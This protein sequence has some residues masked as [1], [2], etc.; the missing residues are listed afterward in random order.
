MGTCQTNDEATGFACGDPGDTACT[1]P[2]T[3]NG[4][5]TCL[6]NDEASGFACGSP[7][8]T[9]CSNPDT[10]NGMGSCAV[11][12]EA[13]G[14]AC[15]DPANTACSN[16]DI[17]DGAGNCSPNNEAAGFACGDPADT[18][19]TNPDTCNGSGT[20]QSN[21]EAAG[22]PCRPA[23]GDCDAAEA[24]DGSG[25][26][27]VDGFLS[28]STECRGPAGDCD[29]AESC[30]GFSATCP[31]DDV[32]TAGTEC[33]GAANTCDVAETCDGSSTAC[34]TDLLAPDGTSCEDGDA[35]TTSDTCT[36]GVCAGSGNSC[37]VDTFMCYK[38]KTT[39][40]LP[41]SGV[42]VDDAIDGAT[43]LDVKVHK[44]LCVPSELDAEA[45][46]DA[47]TN[48]T[49]YKVKATGH[50]KQT[51][52]AI[53]NVVGDLSL[54][55][56]RPDLLFV[57]ANVDPMTPPP[58][59][60]GSTHDVNHYKCYKARV[61]PGTPPVPPGATVIVGNAFDAQQLFAVKKVRHLC[62]PVDANGEGIENPNAYLVCYKIAAALG[63]AHY[64]EHDGLQ[65]HDQFGPHVLQSLKQT[66]LCIPSVLAP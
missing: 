29:V 44:H 58:A 50:V 26:C 17:C 18:A 54:D 11:N 47:A 19:C 39:G 66:E 32:A 22:T 28:S 2:D 15:G 33:R 8:D 10:C 60:D 37:A 63:T 25:G 36:G 51:G 64:S 34:P 30:T 49:T 1:N 55:T 14:F 6:A 45:I 43:T 38:S 7:A 13:A 46:T 3:C 42:T 23:N 56:I 20:C 27:P 59:P 48:L 40:F 5:G 52:I 61:T 16:P 12:N 31:T 41:V 53:Q 35:C 24:C 21:N 62:A 57:P 65:A 4:M 9:P